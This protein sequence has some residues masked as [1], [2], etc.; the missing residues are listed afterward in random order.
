MVKR[1]PDDPR[2]QRIAW[3]ELGHALV[4]KKLGLAIGEVVHTGTDGKTMYRAKD[5]QWREYA[6]F[7]MAGSAGEWLWEKHNNGWFGSRSY[8]HGDLALF[9][10]ATEGKRFSEE[11]ARS[12]ARKILQRHRDRLEVLAPK[13]IV[14]GRL[15]G[16]QI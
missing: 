13:L 10:E 11:T 3:H 8:I 1:N 12:K 4:G 6:I 5:D 7:C 9:R 14:A 16:G 2:Q 15:S